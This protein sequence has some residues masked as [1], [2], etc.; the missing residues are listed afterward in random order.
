MPRPGIALVLAAALSTVQAPERRPLPTVQQIVE[1]Y[2]AARGGLARFKAVRSIVLRAPGRFMAANVALP[3]HYFAP[4]PPGEMPLARMLN[5]AFAARATPTDALGW[6]RDFR[7][8]PATAGI[9]T[10]E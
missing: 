4:P 10:E 8:D 1:R 3:P 6:Y 7:T 2:I 5:G 9:D